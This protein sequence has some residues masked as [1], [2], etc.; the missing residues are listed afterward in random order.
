M[1]ELFAKKQIL[2]Q[3]GIQVILFYISE[4]HTDDAWPIGQTLKIRNILSNFLRFNYQFY[5]NLGDF[6]T[7]TKNY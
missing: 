7:N 6:V 3:L 2:D 5:I 4:A 1:E